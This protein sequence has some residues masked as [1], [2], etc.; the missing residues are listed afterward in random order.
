M[1]ML[2]RLAT[3]GELR[4]KGS[5]GD[6]GDSV[7]QA[8]RDGILDGSIA[9]GQRLVELAICDWLKVSRTPARDALR[10]LQSD[11]L[12]EAAPGGGL[13]VVHYDVNALHELYLV[14][15]VLEGTAAAEAARN[16]SSAEILVLQESVELQRG[17]S[18]SIESF[19]QENKHFHEQLYAAAH[20]RFLIRQLKSLTDSVSLLGP[21]AITTSEWIRHAASQHALITEAIGRREADA[22]EQAMRQH[23]RDGFERRLVAVKRAAAPRRQATTRA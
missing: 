17:M 8:L 9:P 19:T 20:N 13:Q 22:A 12:A 10:R 3:T 7:Y 14:R 6:L 15:E 11:G 23:I 16:A 18:R 4:A 21:T 5:R 1:P 2:T